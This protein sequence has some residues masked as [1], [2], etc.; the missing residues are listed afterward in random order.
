MSNELLAVRLLEPYGD[1]SP[2]EVV[3]VDRLRAKRMELDKVGSIEPPATI[4][5]GH[6]TPEEL[7]AAMT[8]A[9]AQ[10]GVEVVVPVSADTFRIAGEGYADDVE[11]EMVGHREA[12]AYDRSPADKMVRKAPRRKG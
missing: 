2:G 5:P 4:P 8:K 10:P 1:K 6:Y 3:L 9:L 7:A 11:G 12:K